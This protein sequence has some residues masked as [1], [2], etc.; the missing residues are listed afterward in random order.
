M[1]QQHLLQTN[2]QTN[3]SKNATYKQTNAKRIE[4]KCSSSPMDMLQWVKLIYVQPAISSVIP[5][6]C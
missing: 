3:A 5:D 6:K 4:S 1:K 2:R